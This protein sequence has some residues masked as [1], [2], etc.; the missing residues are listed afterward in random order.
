[1]GDAAQGEPIKHEVFTTPFKVEPKF[2]SWK[3]P[4]NYRRYPGGKKLPAEIK[5]WRVQDTGKAFG[6][7]VSRSYGFED[8]PD[9]EV[10]TPGFNVGKESGA[11]GVGRHGNFLQWGFSAPPSKMTDAGRKFFLNC[12]WYIRKFDG[13][14]P[15]VRR[16]DSHR[17]NAVRLAALLN[18]IKNPRF[19]AITF[20]AELLKKYAG[21][22]DGLVKHYRDNFELI[23]HDK[24]FLVDS[25]LKAL[26]IVSNRKVA[27]LERLVA[28]LGLTARASIARK[29]LARYTT[30]S[31]Q[32]PA[33]WRGWLQ[34]NR[35]RI[36]FSDVGG[37]K[38]RVVPK[39]YLQPSSP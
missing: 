36:Y 5:V 9:A 14:G 18:K 38:F 33:E 27:T 31:F 13:K 6:G 39:G 26:G 19:H 11:V 3:T 7:V 32:T 35:D 34:A 12:I 8:S 4:S 21:D 20:P 28:L 29:L 2:E 16:G 24:R 17:M 15:L 22:P 1:M 25:E 37:Y 23:Y 30:Q 10:L